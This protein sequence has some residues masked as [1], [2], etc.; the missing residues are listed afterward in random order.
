MTMALIRKD[1][2]AEPRLR[3]LV[4]PAPFWRAWARLVLR[5][6]AHAALVAAY[7]GACYA[8]DQMF[9]VAVR[10]EP[11]DFTVLPAVAL[12]WL[13]FG[14]RETLLAYGPARATRST[15]RALTLYPISILAFVL[16]CA[17]AGLA[18]HPAHWAARLFGYGYALAAWGDATASAAFM[19]VTLFGPEL[20]RIGALCL[21]LARWALLAAYFYTGYLI[22][23]QI[24]RLSPSLSLLLL[25]LLLDGLKVALLTCGPARLTR[26]IA[27]RVSAAK[28]PMAWWSPSALLALAWVGFAGDCSTPDWA[29]PMGKLLV[30]ASLNHFQASVALVI[31]ALIEP[32]AARARARVAAALRA[33]ARRA[34]L[35][36]LLDADER[37]VITAAVNKK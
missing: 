16:W 30:L 1:Q 11:R 32:E 8:Q 7:F 14:L 33:A 35:A 29:W 23:T 2:A 25:Q 37:V 28:N 3:D 13:L 17:Y 21:A 27:A 10:A 4:P 24:A 15:E 18:M 26:D 20:A 5:P 6:L 19:L 12:Q 22:V 34:L 9:N 31:V 36:L